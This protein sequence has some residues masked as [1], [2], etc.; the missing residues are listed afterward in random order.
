MQILVV[1]DHR[2]FRD[3]LL[4]VLKRIDSVTSILEASDGESAESIL[5]DEEIDLALVDY[6]LPDTTGQALLKKIKEEAPEIPVIIMSGAEDPAMI[7]SALG[8]GASGF[9]PKSMEPD[10]LVDAINIVLRGEYFVPPS[11]L[12]HE[13]QIINAKGIDYAD[14]VH[15]AKVTEQ[16]IKTS[17]WSIRAQRESS[18][19]PETIEAFN[20]LLERMENQYN[21]LRDQAF[22]D[23]LT[24][25][26]NR[27]LFDDRLALA[28]SQAKRGKSK[29][30]LIAMDLDKFKQ[31]NDELGHDQGDELLKAVAERLLSSTREVDTVARLGG[32]E[33]VAIITEAASEEAVLTAAKR[34]FDTIVQKLRLNG[35]EITPSVSMGIAV[36]DGSDDTRSLFRAADEALYEVKK[37]GRN[38]YRLYNAIS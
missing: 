13:A 28:A 29:F 25:L 37:Q 18:T 36:S 12:K 20:K 35:E 30:A 1:D 11:V 5:D 7:N 2:L 8:A 26:P 14:L 34:I 22:R 31:I 3:G 16:V 17:D 4:I 6:H 38:G 10:E 23:A 24:G 15:M 33:F 19:R 27:R 9:L 32:D 21:E